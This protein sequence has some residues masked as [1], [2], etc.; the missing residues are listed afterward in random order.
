MAA[1]DNLGPL[2]THL[3]RMYTAGNL[4]RGGTSHRKAPREM[5]RRPEAG[6]KEESRGLVPLGPRGIVEISHGIR[7]YRMGI[8]IIDHVIM[9]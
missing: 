4:M 6:W 2:Y 7:K 5:G 8:M 1:V 3:W 9:T